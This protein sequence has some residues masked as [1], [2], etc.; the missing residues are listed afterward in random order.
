MPRYNLIKIE[1][2]LNSLPLEAQR[3]VFDFIAFMKLKYRKRAKETH[4]DD[5]YWTALSEN[6]LNT[7]WD[8]EEDEVYN[9]LLQG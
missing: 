3:E 6:S 5:V 2:D 1:H 8:N 9:E 7:V 4:E